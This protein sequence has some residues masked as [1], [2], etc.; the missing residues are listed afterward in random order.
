MSEINFAPR[1]L[2]MPPFLLYVF[3]EERVTTGTTEC[4]FS[5]YIGRGN[6]NVNAWLVVDRKS[7]PVRCR[8]TMETTRGLY[9]YGSVSRA[10]RVA[11]HIISRRFP[12]TTSPA[13]NAGTSARVKVTRYGPDDAHDGPQMFR[14]PSTGHYRRARSICS[15][16]NINFV[17]LSSPCHV[18]GRG[19]F[20]CPSHGQN[21]Y[22]IVSAA[23]SRR[24]D[25]KCC[26]R[27]FGFR[28][29]PHS[30]SIR[31]DPK[32]HRRL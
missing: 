11:P 4:L 17:L 1:G 10:G 8:R 3:R 6:R 18:R 28:G 31:I 20:L 32:L 12:A 7:I 2:S 22:G 30:T 9:R 15:S 21:R 24:R 19:L 13:R 27:E 14:F 25:R 16:Y 23:K 5:L 26:S 29:L